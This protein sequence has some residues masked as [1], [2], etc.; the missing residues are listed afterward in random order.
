LLLKRFIID[1]NNKLFT[2]WI[3]GYLTVSEALSLWN[4][5]FETHDYN[6]Y[7]GKL[8]HQNMMMSQIQFLLT[9]KIFTAKDRLNGGGKLLEYFNADNIYQLDEAQ[10]FI[11]VDSLSSCIVRFFLANNNLEITSMEQT[12]G[13]KWTDLFWNM[14]PHWFGQMIAFNSEEHVFDVQEMAMVMLEALG[15][16]EIIGELLLM[17]IKEL[18]ERPTPKYYDDPDNPPIEKCITLTFIEVP[19]YYT[20][21]GIIK[22]NSSTQRKYLQ[23][24]ID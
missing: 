20:T 4:I 18:N 3:N 14:Y 8:I 10:M 12:D 22:F 7:D 9:T 6:E 15:L 24:K 19:N 16:M 2:A 13:W 23:R 5:S 17:G 1:Y 11:L 21:D